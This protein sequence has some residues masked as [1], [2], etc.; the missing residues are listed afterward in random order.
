[1][2]KKSLLISVL[3]FVLIL[4]VRNSQGNVQ[5]ITYTFWIKEAN[6]SPCFI[7]IILI[8]IFNAVFVPKADADQESC[9]GNDETVTS[10]NQCVYECGSE[11]LCNL[12]NEFSG[13]EL[14]F[15]PRHGTHIGKTKRTMKPPCDPT[16]N[17]K[18]VWDCSV[19]WNKSQQRNNEAWVSD[20]TPPVVIRSDRSRRIACFLF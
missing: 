14:W 8:R 2:W 1:M 12:R 9:H 3:H 6:F 11:S 16:G 7:K 20:L 10:E 19:L 17:P 13:K 5:A 4:K 18:G 15:K